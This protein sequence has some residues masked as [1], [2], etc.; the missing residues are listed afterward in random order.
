MLDYSL[1]LI[2]ELYALKAIHSSEEPAGSG[3]ISTALMCETIL[4]FLPSTA[5]R[6]Q[7]YKLLRNYQIAPLES[8]VI[9]REQHISLK[10]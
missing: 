9:G 7:P 3:T 5:F 8:G 4:S 2:N 6:D 1:Q 10:G